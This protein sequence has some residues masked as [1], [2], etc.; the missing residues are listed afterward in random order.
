ML[1]QFCAGMLLLHS[2]ANVFANAEVL[3][4]IFIDLQR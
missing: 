4:E 3:E 1:K 2:T